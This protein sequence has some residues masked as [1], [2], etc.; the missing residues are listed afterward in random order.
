MNKITYAL[1]LSIFVSNPT[2]AAT[3]SSLYGDIDGG[4]ST[5]GGFG[6][7]DKVINGD[8]SWNHFIDLDGGTIESASLTIGY[9]ALGYLQTPALSINELFV[10]TIPDIDP[11]GDGIADFGLN[12]CGPSNYYTEVVHIVDLS[13]FGNGLNTF[14]ID[15]FVSDG[16]ILD[17]SQFTYAVEPS[18]VPTPAAIWLFGIGMIGLGFARRKQRPGIPA[19]T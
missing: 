5:T 11:C 2:I 19:N 18:V 10:A 9:A 3:I 15:T 14:A 4:I 8:Q 16:W 1:V 12:F 7:T 13:I 17:Y 6:I